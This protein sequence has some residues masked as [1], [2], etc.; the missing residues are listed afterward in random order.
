VALS[1]AVP[2]DGS[3]YRCKYCGAPLRVGPDSVVVVC[4]YCGKPNWVRG[5]PRELYA[6]PSVSRDEAE[7]AFIDF[8]KRDPDLRGLVNKGLLGVARVEIVFIPFYVARGRVGGDYDYRGVVVKTRTVKRGDRYVT[9]TTR[10]PFHERGSM[11]TSFQ[12][13]A[14]AKRVLGEEAADELAKHFAEKPPR[15][16]RLDEIE[17]RKGEYTALAA[18]YDADEAKARI[19]DDVCDWF[20]EWVDKEVRNRVSRRH[21]G[22]RVEVS[23]RSITCRPS[24]GDL[25][26][27]VLLP[28]AKIF[29]TVSG[30]IYRAFFAAWD[31]EPLVREEPLTPRQRIALA[32]LSGAIGG[33]GGVAAT[34]S[35][36]AFHR[37]V[38]GGVIGFLGAAVSY[39]VARLALRPSRIETGGPRSWVTSIGEELE[40]ATRL[41]DELERKAEA[42]PVRIAVG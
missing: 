22:G 1:T 41:I 26:G 16:R 21:G 5:N 31:M 35:I 37:P 7:R 30:K 34:A 29:Y 4:P 20:R 40:D 32:I 33:L 38:A 6:A 9:E 8:A 25:S 39:L 18:D 42:L 12:A 19:I 23:S 13:M 15:L 28:L 17:W 11:E 27:P 2:R 3:A 10:I 36:V 24:I 14:S